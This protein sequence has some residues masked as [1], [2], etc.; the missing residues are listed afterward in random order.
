MA[1]G[2]W[3]LPE[4]VREIA[5]V[6]GRERAL[7]LVGQVLKWERGGHYGKSAYLYVPRK[8]KP[9]HR[10]EKILGRVDA[11]ALVDEFGGLILHISSC[12]GV[13]TRS[14][15]REIRRMAAAGASNDDVV[16]IHGITKRHVL[17]IKAA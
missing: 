10:L 7:Y 5:A 13:V 3:D 17:A 4:T 1:G 8:L 12:K 6:I 16:T 9:S 15:D 2:N 11:A 14:R